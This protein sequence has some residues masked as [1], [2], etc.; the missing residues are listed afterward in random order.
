MLCTFRR[1][2]LLSALIMIAT[3]FYGG[4]AIAGGGASRMSAVDASR[5]ALEVEVNPFRG[6]IVDEIIVKGN[7]HTRRWTIIREMATKEGEHLDEH[8]LYRD[9]S[10]LRGLGFFS[11]VNITIDE[12]EAGHCDLIVEVSERP[13]L[14]MKYPMPLLNYDMTRGVSYGVRWKVRNFQSSRGVD[15]EEP[16]LPSSR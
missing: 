15:T 12:T 2:Y 9:H 14:F 16:M 8:V 1:V 10:Y 5:E 3:A 7:T 11:E 4:E 13:N 6:S